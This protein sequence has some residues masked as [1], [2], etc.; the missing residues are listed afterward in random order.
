MQCTQLKNA[1]TGNCTVSALLPSVFDTAGWAFKCVN[2][3]ISD[4]ADSS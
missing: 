3:C 2:I 1:I 4:E